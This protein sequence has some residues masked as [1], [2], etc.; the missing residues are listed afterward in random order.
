MLR[1]RQPP[2]IGPLRAEHPLQLRWAGRG[3][4]LHDRGRWRGRWGPWNLLW[5]R[6][7]RSDRGP[8]QLR[9]LRK[10]MRLG[11]DLSPGIVR[12]RPVSSGVPRRPLSPRG[13][14]GS[15]DLLRNH[16]RTDHPERP[17]LRR[18]QPGLRRR[19]GMRRLPVPLSDPEPGALLRRPSAGARQRPFLA[20]PAR[21]T[22]ERVYLRAGSAAEQGHAEPPQRRRTGRTARPHR[23]RLIATGVDRQISGQDFHLL[24][25][26][27]VTAHYAV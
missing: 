15:W 25:M 9:G 26:C 3:G 2:D 27:T 19:L 1:R 6:V 12:L 17:E 21:P 13:R 14:P 20:Q 10:C 22:R 4:H 5:P 7:Q 8:R 18:L 23:P 24:V 11:R 16:V